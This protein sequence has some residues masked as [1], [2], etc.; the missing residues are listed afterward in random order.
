VVESTYNDYKTL[1]CS[2]N[3][4]VYKNF[5][6]KQRKAHSGCGQVALYQNDLF[7]IIESKQAMS[8]TEWI[9][10]V[11]PSQHNIVYH[12]RYNHHSRYNRPALAIFLQSL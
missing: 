8:E 11:P 7:E 3:L 5:V 4:Q 10:L 12:L 1:F 9:F 2:L 6:L